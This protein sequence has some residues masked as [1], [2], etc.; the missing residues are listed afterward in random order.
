MPP[1]RTPI[2]VVAETTPLLACRGPLRVAS[3][4]L[5]IEASVALSTEE[6][7]LVVVAL[8]VVL[9]MKFALVKYEVEEAKSPFTN[10]IGV[11]VEFAAAPKLV[12]GVQEKVPLPDPQATP[13]LERSP[14]VEKVAQP[15]VPPALE[16]TRFVVLAVP[17]MVRAVVEA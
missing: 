2:E 7:R 10:Q 5:V 3:V 15:A 12:V 13:V 9:L 1:Y 16:T 14:M 4:R 8:V 11:E 17:E 6:K